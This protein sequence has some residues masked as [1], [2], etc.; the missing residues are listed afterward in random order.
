MEISTTKFKIVAKRAELNDGCKKLVTI[1]SVS[2]SIVSAWW[3]IGPYP[4]FWV[5][6]ECFS[7]CIFNHFNLYYDLHLDLFFMDGFVF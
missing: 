6:M 1:D 4:G 7:L 3:H 5:G 2:Y